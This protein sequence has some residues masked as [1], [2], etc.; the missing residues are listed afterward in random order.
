VAA[1]EEERGAVPYTLEEGEKFRQCRDGDWGFGVELGQVARGDLEL[2]PAVPAGAVEPVEVLDVL[3]A[4]TNLVGNKA[5]PPAVSGGG[6]EFKV[7]EL[8]KEFGGVVKVGE[9][10]G[11]TAL[12]EGLEVDLESNA[13]LQI[14]L[15]LSLLVFYTGKAKEWL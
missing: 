14:T 8:V 1:W 11:V 2:Q 6:C 10:F 7:A 3:F 5:L 15:L 13:K 9:G 12:E 4:S